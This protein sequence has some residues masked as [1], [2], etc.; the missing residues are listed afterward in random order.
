MRLSTISKS[1]MLYSNLAS[2]VKSSQNPKKARLSGQI[3]ISNDRLDRRAA[4]RTGS[5]PLHARL[6]R[7]GPAHREVATGAREHAGRRGPAG[8]AVDGLGPE[9]RWWGVIAREVYDFWRWERVRRF[10][11]HGISYRLRA[12]LSCTVT[13]TGGIN[14]CERIN[15][16]EVARVGC[17][18]VKIKVSPFSAFPCLASRLL[19]GLESSAPSKGAPFPVLLLFSA[20][21]PPPSPRP[22]SV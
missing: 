3:H 2:K 10:G 5:S 16:R 19:P 17:K 18:F 6:G 21:P 14:S 22:S 20:C 11:R 8:H 1:A 9:R 12:T 13:G 4:H 15:S 7:T